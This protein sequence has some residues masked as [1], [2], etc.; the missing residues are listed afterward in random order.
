MK[1]FSTLQRSQCTRFFCIGFV[2]LLILAGCSTLKPPQIARFE[3]TPTTIQKGESSTLQWS[4]ENTEQTRIS[5]SG[6]GAIAPGVQSSRISPDETTTYTLQVE[7]D[8]KML[9]ERT[10]TVNVVQPPQIVEFEAQPASIKQGETSTL[11]WTVRNDKG[12]KI[13]IKGVGTIPENS[14]SV[15]VTPDQTTSFTLQVERDNKVIAE[16]SVSVTVAP[17]YKPPVYV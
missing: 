3:A 6:I 10:A 5:I 2:G 9:A 16:K 17:A 8:G 15:R 11:R 12:V 4:I 13:S 1:Y 7:R 14:N